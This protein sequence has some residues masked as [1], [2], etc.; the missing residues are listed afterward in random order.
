MKFAASDFD[1]TLYRENTITREDA[2]AIRAWRK[3][4]HKFGVVSGRDYGI[5]VPML[6]HY[7][8][9]YDYLATNNGALITDADGTPLFESEIAPETLAAIAK[10][11]R[12]QDSFHYALAAAGVTY[13][14][15]E[16]EGSW[17]R[18]EATEWGAPIQTVEEKD[19]AHLPK[20]VHQF[21]L[22]YTTPEASVAAADEINAHFGNEVHAFPNRCALDIVPRGIHKEQAIHDALKCMK[23][24]GAEIYAIGD[25]VNDLPMIEAYH[26][27]TV[28]TARDAIKA[29][30]R[31]VYKSVG[32]MLLDNL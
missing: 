25:E 16:G 20:K 9:T 28:D 8:V 14:C 19:L 10:L 2:E 4:G 15:H 1:G 6:I 23:W 24:E 7:G 32:A 12:V 17:E 5:L 22:G 26:G 30:A 21:A 31:H 29:K 3:A 13:L 11:P 18:P 27:F